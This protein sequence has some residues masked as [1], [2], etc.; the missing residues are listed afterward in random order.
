MRKPDE[1]NRNED[2][3]MDTR[4]TR[5]DHNRNVIIREKVHIKPINIFLKKKR[6]S[7]FGEMQ[8][9]EH[10]KVAKSVLN[11]QIEGYRPRGRPKLR[12]MDHLK[13]DMTKQTYAQRGLQTETAG[14]TIYKMST[15]HRK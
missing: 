14:S 6:L 8:R 15:L 13:Q 9:R 4:Q 10:D 5:K 11:N 12:W 7:W 1:H 2:A 3:E